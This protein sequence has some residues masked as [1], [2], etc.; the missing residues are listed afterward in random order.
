[1]GNGTADWMASPEVKFWFQCAAQR[2]GLRA[3]FRKD[4]YR[5]TEERIHDGNLL[6]AIGWSKTINPGDE[7]TLAQETRQALSAVKADRLSLLQRFDEDG[8]GQIDHGEWEAARSAVARDV[9]AARAARSA[10]G[11]G[12]HTMVKPRDRRQ[13]FLLSTKPQRHLARHYRLASWVFGFA[14]VSLA[15]FLVGLLQMQ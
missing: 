13:P 2:G 7:I 6:Y 10:S 1:M 15:L 4:R 3:V 14:A 5:Y 11:T 12:V 9:L 8:D